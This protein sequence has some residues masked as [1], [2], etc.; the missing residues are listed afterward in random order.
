MTDTLI[1]FVDKEGIVQLLDKVRLP[2]G[3]PVLVTILAGNDAPN[4]VKLR[5]YG[6]CAGEFVVP[7]DFDDPL[8]SDVLDLF[9][10]R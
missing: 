7:D 9:E 2:Q 5:P 6:L 8:P 1:G 4:S 10:G 3:Q